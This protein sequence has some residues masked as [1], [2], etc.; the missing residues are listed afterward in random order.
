MLSKKQSYLLTAV[1]NFIILGCAD[2][3][4]LIFNSYPRS[5][6]IQENVG[7]LMVLNFGLFL[8]LIAAITPG[9]QTLQDWAR[10]RH[11]T[12][13]KE[14]GKTSV[15]YDLIWG[16]K[17]PGILAIAINAIISVTCLSCFVLISQVSIE[18]KTNSW[19]ALLFAGSL[20]VIY[21]ALTQLI[22]FMKNEQRQL[23]AT[24]VLVSFIILPP[25]F[26]GIFFPRPENYVIVWL[27]SI[28][29]PL[30]ALSSSKSTDGL[31]LAYFL[32]ILGHFAIAAFLVSQLTRKLK[33][34]GESATKALLTASESAIS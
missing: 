34:A 22:L 14:L 4:E 5:Y 28:A 21:A 8:Y 27:F 33:K 29:A 9:R 19:M 25:I 31:L 23:W 7:L 12:Q 18:N 1:F 30:I 6:S 24:G 13:P 15:I 2:W 20:A 26:L 16:D 32:A 11:I 3:Q 17:S 10:Y